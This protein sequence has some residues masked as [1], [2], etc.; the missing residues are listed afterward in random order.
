MTETVEALTLPLLPLT[1]GVVLPQMVVT[2]ALETAEARDAAD[3]AIA[4]DRRVLLVPR[5]GAGYARV[6][7][8]ARIENEG[9]LPGGQRALVLRGLSRAVVGRTVPER[10]PRPVGG[11]RTRGRAVDR[12]RTGPRDGARVP[13]RRA[14]HRREAGHAPHRRGP[15][16]RRRP[17]RAGRHRRLVARPV[18][19]A[20]GRAAGD[21]R[22][23]GAPREGA[24]LAARD[25]GRARAEGADPQRRHRR[26][27]E[28]AARVPAAPADGR[29]P[30]GAGRA[31][32][33]RR[34]RGVPHQ[35][36]RAGRQGR[37]ARRRARG[38]RARDRPLERTSE[39]N[40]EHGWIRT[41]LD[42]VLEL[43]WGDSLRRDARR[44][45]R[46]RGSSTPTTPASTT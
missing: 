22:R 30:Q 32:T 7:T 27:G 45:W 17:R 35:A 28:D 38:D 40:P 12:V 6:G 15:G 4:G 16:R 18:G 2:L 11:G 33:R 19:R 13:R 8:V 36:G 5:V 34:R 20:Q 39:Q 3:G 37:A 10:P 1:T 25:A 26:H 41:W 23:R 21:A 24:G 42:T 44:R 29:D 43:P 9:E 31:A 46:A 14:R